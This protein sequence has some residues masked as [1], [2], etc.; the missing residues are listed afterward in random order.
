MG[1]GGAFHPEHLKEGIE[2]WF[3]GSGGLGRIAKKLSKTTVSKKVI[4]FG[5]VDYSNAGEFGI[6][7]EIA[8]DLA[9]LSDPYD[10][11]LKEGGVQV[12]NSPII[13]ETDFET[14][15]YKPV[16]EKV[17]KNFD[18]EN[19]IL[20]FY[21]YSWGANIVMHICDRLNADGIKVD[22]LLTIDGAKGPVSFSVRTSVPDN[23]KFNLNI[24][25]SQ[26]SPIGSHGY[27]NSGKRVTNVDLTGDTNA[28]GMAIVHS[29]I[30]DY[31]K[32]F[33]IQVI[34]NALRG[35]KQYETMSVDQIKEKIKLY[36]S[37]Q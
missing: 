21:G 17:K 9:L 18:P 32:L 24:Y 8:N 31:T 34:V 15:I 2:R 25:Q 28:K 12:F 4:L 6:N 22:F 11:N 27:A 33:S 16:L 5:G 7:A 35:L 26:M 20:V 1:G 36:E 23:V 14:D 37:K 19:G 10:L 30:D 29:N 13:A 3:D